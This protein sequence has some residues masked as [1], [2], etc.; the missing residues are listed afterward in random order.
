MKNEENQRVPPI[1]YKWLS[2]KY[3]QVFIWQKKRRKKSRERKV[4]GF[5]MQ[6]SC[7]SK[8]PRETLCHFRASPLLLVSI[9]NNLV[10]RTTHTTRTN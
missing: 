2:A 4:H 7:K 10:K 3:H 6:I 8:L 5:A 9:K 1:T